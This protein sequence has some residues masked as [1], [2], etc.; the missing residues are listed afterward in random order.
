VYTSD[1][2][3]VPD[4]DADVAPASGGDTPPAR[5]AALGER[6]G[7]DAATAAPPGAATGGDRR[8]ATLSV[9]HGDAQARG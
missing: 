9:E 4:P 1:E 2:L 5:T 6:T 8:S 7:D 3:G